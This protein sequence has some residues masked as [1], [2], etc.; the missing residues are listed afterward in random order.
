MLRFHNSV[1][2]GYLL[3][4]GGQLHDMIGDR[5]LADIEAVLE[6]FEAAGDPD[7][8]PAGAGHPDG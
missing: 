6:R 3:V 8:E 5:D 4:D 1:V 7:G 2:H